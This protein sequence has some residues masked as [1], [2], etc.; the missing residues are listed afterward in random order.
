MKKMKAIILAVAIIVILGLLTGCTTKVKEEKMGTKEYNLTDFSKIEVGGAFEV[1]I[2]QSDTYKVSVTAG[3]FPHIRIEKSGDTLV[4]K[5]QGFDWLAPFN[6]RPNAKVTLPLLTGLDISGASHGTLKNFQS[7]KEL[8][9][10]LSGASHVKAYGVSAGNVDIKV[11][12]ASTLSG[13]IKA[14]QDVK[15][16]VSG[17][18]K[19]DLA[20][21]GNNAEMLVSGA[22]KAELN[23]F[24]VQN[25]QLRVS[26]A[27]HALVNLN[28][29]LDA[30][31]SGASTL[32]WSGSPVMRNIQISGAAT[33]KAR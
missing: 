23:A 1:E 33:L 27:S 11:S 6:G 10:T 9:V 4:I 17:A 26:G 13:D 28:G 15:F 2:E 21:A 14:R 5:R 3:D 22:S 12:G 32:L 8:S 7:D 16:E 30:N 29:K 25:A 31:V 19:I 24:A 18:S 20:G